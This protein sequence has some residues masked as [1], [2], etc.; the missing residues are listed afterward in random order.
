[1]VE[2]KELLE[3]SSMNM[4]QFSE[5]FDIPYRTLQNWKSEERKCP[6][7]VTKLIEYKLKS[8]GMVK[9]MT[10]IEILMEDGCT[11]EDA[12][13]HLEVGTIVF[14]DFEDHLDS[15]CAELAKGDEELEEELKKMVETKEPAPDWGIVE[16]S[17]KTYYI[18]Y[19]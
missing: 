8:E 5:Y 12:Q 15:Y 16:L 6:D 3:R 4:K 14:D 13:R 2:F 1:M 10:D 18:M 17:G 19:C 11:R 9:D 7:Y